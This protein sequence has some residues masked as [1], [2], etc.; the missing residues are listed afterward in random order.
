[1]SEDR[2]YYCSY[3]FKYLKI[4]LVSNKTLNCHAAKSHAIDFSWLDKNPGQL[5]NIQV[6]V[7]ERQLMLDNQRN[8]SCEE[9]CWP[10]EDKGAVSPRL[11]QQ[12]NNKTHFEIRTQPEILEIKLNDDCNL[13]CSYC[14]KDF[15]SAWRRD[16]VDHGNYKINTGDARY[17]LTDYDKIMMNVS[18]KEVKKTAKFQTLMSEIKNFSSGLKEIVV[19][20]GEPLLDNQL[21]DVLDA[22]TNSSAVINIYTGLGVELQR[23]QRMLDKIKKSP[24]ALLSISAECTN[25]FY[26]FNRY[27][28][29]W[30]N[31]ITRI[32][33]IKSSGIDF[34]FSTT[35]TN[36]TVFDLPMFIQLFVDQRIGL[37]FANHPHM[38][39][40]YVLD[41]D[42]KQQ[43]M[44][45]IKSLPEHYQT[46]IAQSI[47]ADPSELQRQQMSEFLKEYVTRRNLDTSI[48]PKTFLEWLDIYVVQ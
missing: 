34:R 12:G 27:G 41:P 11:W 14:C 24:T 23:F 8:Y 48:Y 43:I 6:N 9:N 47:Q 30:D 35:I 46:Q 39:A 25:K 16:L 3:K 4:D 13:S 26:E 17:Q 28:N 45:N 36:L 5:F 7:S 10:L 44:Q 20:G 2:D 33:M 37:V 31:F 29:S 21:F 40:P 38:M 15:S 18:Q 42:S 19:T 32:E 1:M 22:V